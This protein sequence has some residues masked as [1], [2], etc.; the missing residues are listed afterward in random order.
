MDQRPVPANATDVLNPLTGL[1]TAS[2]MLRRYHSKTC[3][4]AFT[5]PDLT[6]AYV[7]QSAVWNMYGHERPWWSVLTSLSPQRDVAPEQKDRFY[8]SGEEHVKHVMRSMRDQ[9]RGEPDLGWL[10]SNESEA[11]TAMK[12]TRTLLDFGCGLGR[13][14]HSFAAH[15]GRI[16][17]VD[18]SVH[19]LRRA[20]SEIAARDAERARRIAWITTTPDLLAALGGQRPDVLHTVIAMQHTPHPLQ[21]AYFEQLCDALR[22]GGVGYLHVITSTS[23]AS[24]FDPCNLQDVVTRSTF[25]T[26]KGMHMHFT[27]STEIQR[28]FERRGCTAIVRAANTRDHERFTNPR[29]G[30]KIVMLTKSAAREIQ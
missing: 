26:D 25:S 28:I 2:G 3:G 29:V 21:V 7:A 11:V 27:P 8:R 22:P 23:E 6:E 10:T 30:S 13:L 5:L 4:R 1:V 9:F 16:L 14:A 24:R 15:F 18:Q 17:C 20:Q 12:D 19:H